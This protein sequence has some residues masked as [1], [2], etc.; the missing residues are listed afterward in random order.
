MLHMHSRSVFPN[1][2]SQVKQS[3]SKSKKKVEGN[4]ITGRDVEMVM[5]TIRIWT[6]VKD[7]DN[8]REKSSHSRL[9]RQTKREKI[10]Y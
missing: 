1:I 8:F 10:P 9:S 3:E 6:M 5:L 2:F 4:G 7:G